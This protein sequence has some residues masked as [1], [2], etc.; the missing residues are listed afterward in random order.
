MPRDPVLRG[1]EPGDGIP[2][3]PE[4]VSQEKNA[5]VGTA[6]NLDDGHLDDHLRPLT[7]DDVVGQRK[8]VERLRIVLEASRRRGDPLSHLLLDGPPES[9]RPPWQRFCHVNWVSMSRSPRARL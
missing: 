5:D 9:A 7:L 2:D 4:G 1:P 6:I 8:V 3:P